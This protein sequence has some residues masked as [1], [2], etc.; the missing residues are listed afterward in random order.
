[1]R[2]R[3]WCVRRVPARGRR[4]G[5]RAE[6]NGTAILPLGRGGRGQRQV[7]S[8]PG[9]GAGAEP[10]L[11]EANDVDAGPG[12]GLVEKEGM[13]GEHQLTLILFGF[14]CICTVRLCME[15]WTE[16]RTVG[17]TD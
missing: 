4:V 6:P 10:R 16:G 7:V 9:P 17:R 15:A 11:L 5:R 2:R 3:R 14:T 13:G 8:P 12:E 1:M